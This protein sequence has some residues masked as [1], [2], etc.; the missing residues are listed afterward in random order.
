MKTEGDLGLIEPA[1]DPDP[2]RGLPFRLTTSGRQALVALGVPS[3][4]ASD[5]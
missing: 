3:S 5:G 1:G 2:Q 4:E